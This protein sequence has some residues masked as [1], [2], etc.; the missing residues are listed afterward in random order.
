MVLRLKTLEAESGSF[1]LS[2]T[3]I[4]AIAGSLG[5]F[6]LVVLISSVAFVVIKRRKK[7]GQCKLARPYSQGGPNNREMHFL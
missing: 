5:G 6:A 2:T 4:A 7:K 3:V 1:A